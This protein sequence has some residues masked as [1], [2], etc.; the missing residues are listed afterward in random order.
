MAG[1]WSARARMSGPLVPFVA[2]FEVELGRVGYMPE[3]VAHQLRLVAHFDGWLAERGFDA[4]AITP[5]VIE[6][7]MEPRRA[8][9]VHMRSPKA[10]GPLVEYLQALGVLAPEAETAAVAITATERLLDHYRRYLSVERGLAVSTVNGYLSVV[11]PFVAGLERDDL[12]DFGDLRP[13][14]VAAFVVE[15]CR[16]RRG[17]EVVTAMRSLLRFLH[18]EGLIGSE[19]AAAV[20][21]VAAWQLA[22]LPHPLTAR[23]VLLLLGSCDRSTVAG[24]RDLAILTVLARLGLRAGEVAAMELEDIDWQAG[25]I[26]V[27]NGKR[28][29][30]EP[31]PLPVDVG[32]ALADYLRAG[33]PVG[34]GTR[35]VFV[36]VLAPWDGLS[37]GAIGDVVTAA[38]RRAGVDCVRSRRLR[39]TTAS[40]MLRAGAGLPEIGQ[41]L[42]HRLPRTTAIYAKV[43]ITALRGI[44]R[45]W[46]GGVS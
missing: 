46:P 27:R 13:R 39:Q 45:S 35:C 15:R 20:P 34:I 37:S 1:G 14:D 7:F 5:T 26:V 28:G 36:R 29:R 32:E 38:C 23:D 40:E 10:L 25:L 33:R 43:D 31:L 6:E 30:R 24:R 3:S 12:L 22:G 41:V 17:R 19:L 21:S 2:G 18:L 11:T 8:A 44:A 4:G 9:G 42:R 16:D